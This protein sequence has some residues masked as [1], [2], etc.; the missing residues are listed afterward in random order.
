MQPLLDLDL[1]AWDGGIG[2]DTRELAIDALESGRVVHFPRLAFPL[3]GP[4]LALL[5]PT[6]SDGKAKNVTW[7]ADRQLLKG[8]AS[9][10]DGAGVTALLDRYANTVRR[11]VAALFP[12][13]AG[14][15]AWGPTTLR[16]VEI[17]G[18]APPS[19]R[20][21]KSTRLNSSH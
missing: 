4:E 8:I 18:R 15:L 17:A 20:D 1:A 16:P 11:F 9:D 13:Y 6:I 3:A 19:W 21:R 7:F 10:A 5:D 14:A 12:D 2:Q